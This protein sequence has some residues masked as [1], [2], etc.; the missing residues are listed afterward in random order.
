[1]RQLYRFLTLPPGERRLLMKAALLLALIRLSL[2][3]VPFPVFRRLVVGRQRV[4]LVAANGDRRL[5]DQVVWAVTAV[6]QR[7]PCWASTCL[8]RALTLQAM[9][10]HRGLLS[11]LHVGV[12]RDLQGKLEAH[13]WVEREGRILIGGTPA[14]IDRF[15]P[16]AAFDVEPKEPVAIETAQRSP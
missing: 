12:M 8:S 11:R 1:M 13:A 10:A 4:G 7:A 16:L 2:G 3:M 9:L 6:S 14:D 5:A 15:S